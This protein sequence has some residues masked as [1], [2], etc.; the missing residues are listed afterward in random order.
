MHL[1]IVGLAPVTDVMTFKIFSPKKIAKKLAFFTHTKANLSKNFDHNIGF[2]VNATFFAENCPK[3]TST[4]VILRYFFRKLFGRNGVLSN[5][6]LVDPDPLSAEPLPQ[7]LG[8]RVDAG[9]HVHRHEEPAEQ[10]HEEDGLIDMKKGKKIL[11][12]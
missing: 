3:M 8:H 1:A 5:R 4:P 10:Q 7:V 9:R 11:A 12:E 2:G 6:S